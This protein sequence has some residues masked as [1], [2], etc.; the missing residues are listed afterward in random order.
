MSE[1][2]RNDFNAEAEH[3]GLGTGIAMKH[4]DRLSEKFE[5][6]LTEA[7]KELSDMGIPGIHAVRERILLRGGLH[8]LV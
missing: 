4:F 7:A 6:A 3:I 1:I 5:T 2:V 8:N